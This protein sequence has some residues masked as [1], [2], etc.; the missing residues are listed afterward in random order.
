M[1]GIIGINSN[2]SS[3]ENHIITG[4]KNLEYRGYDS[5]GV[6]YIIN[7]EIH[8]IK[9]KGKINT[10]ESEL[11]SLKIKSNLMIGHTRWATHG[12]AN[13]INAHPHQTEQVSVVHNG[14]IE[15]YIK[16]KKELISL[17]HE[18]KS[19]TDSEVIPHLVTYYINQHNS[20]L[21][22]IQRT[23]KRLE[24][25]FSIAAIFLNQP[26]IIIVARKGSPLVI[27]HKENQMSVASDAYALSFI[28]DKITYLEEDDIAILQSNKV[29]IYN[30]DKIVERP[31]V[32]IT[33][34]Y[35]DASK[36][37]FPHYML[38]EIFEQPNLLSN[39]INFYYDQENS[40]LNFSN[41]N[42]DFKSITKIT[43]VACGSSYYAAMLA[44]YWLEK[45]TELPIEVDI[46]SE[47]RYRD[48]Y[49]PKNGLAIFLSQSGETADTIAAMRHAKEKG[50][51][52]LSIINV[53]A[54]SLDRESDYSLQCFAG[55]EI[56][57][58]ST[59]GFTSQSII[60][61]LL[62]IHI[63]SQRNIINSNELSSYLELVT[64]IP[65]R[66]AELLNNRQSIK[67]IALKLSKS[68][69]IIFIGR[70]HIYPIALEGALKLKELSYIHAEAI[71]SGEL[72]HGP[73][74]LVDKNVPIIVMAPKNKLFEKIYS[75]AQEVAARNGNL[76][77]I[78]SAE[79][80]E[81]LKS[82][83]NHQIN[84]SSADP[85]IEPIIYSI[86]VQL[87]AYYTAT[88]KGTNVDQPRNLAKSVTVE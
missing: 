19:E 41:L 79:G 26:D 76:I 9:V 86:A 43:L 37:N 1:C 68:E 83:S 72:K 73:I 64:K 70:N 30:D 4:L 81:I 23:I 3:V 33:N 62:S 29:E 51:T 71:A 53:K 69:H 57:V 54:S 63:A 17:G 38:K 80:N 24:G 32:T 21:E 7:E 5:A 75:N 40:Q 16:I 2:N 36:G 18:F 55:P 42:I 13:Q 27:G 60:L 74:A 67:A 45:F 25:A 82:I 50:Q 77:T 15:N 46:A 6:A 61:L 85:L 12:L 56:S 8:T 31:I 10:L 20:P 14:I 35:G 65:G 59:K 49:L 11:G 87:L 44:K 22:A 48:S 78:S 28:T 34:E 84:I 66:I 52:T 58:A 39:I 88:A 47:F